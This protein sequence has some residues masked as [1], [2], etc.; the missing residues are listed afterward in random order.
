M[1]YFY[2]R[3]GMCVMVVLIISTVSVGCRTSIRLY[4]RW[5]AGPPTA[6]QGFSQPEPPGHDLLAAG[7][8]ALPARVS[9]PLGDHRGEQGREETAVLRHHIAQ[10]GVIIVRHSISYGDHNVQGKWLLLYAGPQSEEVLWP[11]V[12]ILPQSVGPAGGGESVAPVPSEISPPAPVWRIVL[13]DRHE[14]ISSVVSTTT[15]DLWWLQTS[16]ETRAIVL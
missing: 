3:S 1:W 9:P 2:G 16:L 12:L 8:G 13:G 15:R 7:P 10:V 11:A 6:P 14:I 5:L 4:Q